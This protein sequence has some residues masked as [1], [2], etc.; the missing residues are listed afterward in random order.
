MLSRVLPVLAALLAGCGTAPPP[1]LAPGDTVR[2]HLSFVPEGPWTAGG[3]GFVLLRLHVHRPGRA[4]PAF[5][6]E[7]DVPVADPHMQARVTFLAGDTPLGDPV[8]FP[9]A[10]EC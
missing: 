2:P 6:S 8:V 7:N 4:E 1:A 3:T 5:L 9:F 10:A